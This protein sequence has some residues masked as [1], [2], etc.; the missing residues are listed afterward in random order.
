[1]TLRCRSCGARFSLSEFRAS[2]DDVLEEL[3][4]DTRCDRL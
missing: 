4:G 2:L 1:V 3:L